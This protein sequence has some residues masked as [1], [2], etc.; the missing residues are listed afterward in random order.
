VTA[1]EIAGAFDAL[2]AGADVA[3]GPA[4]DGGYYLVATSGFQPAI[5]ERIPWSGPDVL[6][7]TIDR[8]RNR[9]LAVGLLPPSYDVDE[10]V[11]LVRLA[12]EIRDGAVLASRTAA[13]LEANG[14]IVARLI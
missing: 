8:A 6:A 1:R 10:A 7:T 12:C 3:L 11:D 9:G 2:E 5:F 14:P 13:W 4:D